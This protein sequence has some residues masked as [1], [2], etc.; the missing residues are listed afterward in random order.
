MVVLTL[1]GVVAGR[2]VTAAR[3]AQQSQ[4]PTQTEAD[5][6][7]LAAGSLSGG[8]QHEEH[9]AGGVTELRFTWD[10]AVLHRFYFPI[11]NPGPHPVRIEELRRD[12]DSFTIV[13]VHVMFPGGKQPFQPVVITAGG[14]L[15]LVLTVRTDEPPAPCARTW[16][17]SLPVRYTVLGVSR[18]EQVPTP[19]VIGFASTAKAC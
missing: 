3:Q 17:E 19:R 2:Q 11:A 15:N 16:I 9:R 10:P 14:D 5:G 4:R 13:D 1:I 7:R 8:S 6:Y 12:L 18:W